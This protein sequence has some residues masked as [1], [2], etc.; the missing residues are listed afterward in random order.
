MNNLFRSII[1]SS[2]AFIF[3]T[4]TLQAAS[5]GT[6]DPRSLAMGG[7]GVSSAISTN[8]AYY[9]P[10]LLSV[11]E[12]DD[13]FSLIAPTIGIRA[14]DPDD[15]LDSFE[16]YQD[17]QYETTFNNS[18]DNFDLNP[19]TTTAGNAASAGQQLLSGLNSLSNK[20]LDFEVHGGVNLAI[21]GK[22]LGFAVH[23]N[24]RGMGGLVL[25][26]TAADTA[27]IQGYIDVL[28]D[29]SNGIVPGASSI[30]T[31]GLTGTFTD[32]TFTSTAS[33]LGAAIMEGG[34]SLSHEFDSL[35]GVA[36]GITPKVVQVTTFDYKV[37][38]ESADTDSEAGKLEYEDSNFDVGIAKR[39]G[40]SWKV[41]LVTK[42]AVSKEYKTVL[43]N[44]IELKPQSRIGV[45][46]HTNWTIIAMDLDITENTGIGLTGEKTQ[47]A[48]LGMELDLSLVQIRMGY[49]HNLSAEAGREAGIA[50]AG[51]GLYLVGFHVDAG[52][53]GNDDELEAAVQ[54]GFQF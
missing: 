21:P 40:E 52:V 30:Y 25:D 10:A 50:S 46:H 28:T 44:T 3:T 48:A 8:A 24:V 49:R 9:N 43:G 47:Y 7:T 16:A 41:G 20:G 27:A 5:F 13:D 36:I 15:L 12:E 35:G 23:A 26:I 33:L 6:F 18:L 53:A 14:Y 2:C 22:S 42:N 39:L 1:V 31:G 37:G 34:L 29:L 51:V 19:S 17:G 4:T 38:V 11:P 32:P 54:L 45:S